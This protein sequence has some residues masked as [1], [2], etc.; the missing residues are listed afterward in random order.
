MRVPI[1]TEEFE[2]HLKQIENLKSGFDLAPFH[3]VI[4]DE[5]GNIIYIN[6]AVEQHTGF[7]REESIGK[8]TADLWGGKMPKSFYE[9]M[10][11]TIKVEKKPFSGET[12]NIKKD[13]TAYWQELLITPALDDEGNI[14]FFI[15][16]EPEISDRKKRE[17]FKDQFISALGH[18]VRNPLTTIRWVLEELLASKGIGESERQDLEKAY[19][20]NK[21]LSD[22]I[23]DLLILSRLENQ[24]Q[25]VELETIRIDEELN[26]IV[27]VVQKKHQNISFSLQNEVGSAP[28]STVKSLALQVFSNIIHNAAE[29]AN[30]ERGEV[31]IKLQRFTQGILFSCHN[32]G[33]P[34]PEEVQA[35][36]FSKI[37]STSGGAGLGLFI[38]KMVCDYLAWRITFKT[39]ESGTTFYVIIPWP[40]Q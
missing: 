29:H 35:K 17:E 12:Q 4:T 40:N 27:E 23:K 6:K 19:L 11:R 1:S 15:G 39:E 16:I 33:A 34:I 26:N 3:V 37:S 8:N 18:Q 2:K 24:T 32:N 10:W 9:E 31:V 20:E 13:G 7:T 36:I 14:K 28:L 22:L 5:N 25:A 30:K 21:T 38:A